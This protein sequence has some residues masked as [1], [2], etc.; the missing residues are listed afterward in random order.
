MSDENAQD[1][2]VS[3][4][5][6][7]TADE[8]AQFKTD[9]KEL[10]DLKAEA[11]QM[12]FSDMTE[13]H[14]Y[15]HEEAKKGQTPS[16]PKV[17]VKPNEP[18]PVAPVVDETAARD[19]RDAKA[20]AIHTY[21]ATQ[22]SEFNMGQMQLDEDK[23]T[24]FSKDELTKAI[25][26]PL[27]GLILKLSKAPQHQGNL[28]SA[29]AEYLGMDNAVDKARKEGADSQKALE[30]AGKSAAIIIGGAPPPAETKGSESEVNDAALVN[31]IAPN[32]AKRFV[33]QN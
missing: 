14:D 9:A 12:G 13:Y 26:G 16:D 28:F 23:R 32:T 20:L 24:P 19:A 21:V 4:D 8:L 25:R 7:I 22:F 33:S 17:A 10:A 15:L 30:D 3:Q 2:N 29:A 31:M 1:A 5:E 27:E 6:T 18:A 11:E